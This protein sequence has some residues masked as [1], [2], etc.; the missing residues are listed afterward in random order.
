MIVD[1]K[2]Y[3]TYPYIRQ[4]DIGTNTSGLFVDSVRPCNLFL[5]GMGGDYD[6][7]TTSNT[8]LYSIEANEEAEKNMNSMIN[9]IGIGGTPVRNAGNEAFQ[10]LYNL[11]LSLPDADKKLE[12]PVFGKV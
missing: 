5:E 4:N 10:A 7:D 1:D 8:G 11:T 3:S 6:G 2:F 12:T 9:L